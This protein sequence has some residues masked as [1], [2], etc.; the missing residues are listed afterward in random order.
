[1]AFVSSSN[2]N[3]NSTNEAVN[4]AHEVS[5][6]STQDGSFTVNGIS[7]RL[8][9]LISPVGSATTAT[10]GDILLGVQSSKKSIQQEQGN[11]KKECACGNNYFHSFWVMVM[12]L[13]I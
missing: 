3:T 7:M 2:N 11:L 5:T 13:V 1:M 12:V 9:V 4:T 6:A 8:L 10:K